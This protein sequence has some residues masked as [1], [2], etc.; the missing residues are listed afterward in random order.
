M[1]S[2]R[3]RADGGPGLVEPARGR[4]RDRAE[5]EDRLPQGR[6]RETRP[7]EP[8]DGQ[9][10]PEPPAHDARASPRRCM[11][12][13]TTA[14]ARSFHPGANTRVGTQAGD[15]DTRHDAA[16]TDTTSPPTS[17]RTRRGRTASPALA[18][19]R[20]FE[21]GSWEEARALLHPDFIARWPQTGECF[22]GPDNYVAVNREHPAPG[23]DA[24]RPAA[25]REPRH[26]RAS[27]HARP[28]RG[29]RS[30]RLLLRRLAGPHPRGDRAL[31]RAV[32]GARVARLL[33]RDRSRLI[34]D[35]YLSM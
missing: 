10:E 2:S 21:A 13:E 3:V 29:R 25:R 8:V 32:A 26:G 28:R 4:V 12:A 22:R 15:E 18:L 27:H 17:G 7:R 5:A 20:L 11:S 19:W 34:I 16:E 30:R 35:K 1:P 24:D 6:V 14:A 9:M 33:G 23:L 31:G